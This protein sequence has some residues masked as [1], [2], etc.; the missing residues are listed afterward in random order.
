GDRRRRRLPSGYGE[1]PHVPCPA[2]LEASAV[3]RLVRLALGEADERPCP[4]ERPASS[5]GR[6][7]AALVCRGAAQGGGART[8]RGAS[9]LLRRL[10][11]SADYRAAPDPRVPRS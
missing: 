8:C 9:L 11:Q 10:P 7:A 5:R 3:W 4:F 2:T 6:G 1:D